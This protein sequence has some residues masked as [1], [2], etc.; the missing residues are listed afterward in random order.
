MIE[1]MGINGVP[2]DIFY[3]HPKKISTIRFQFAVDQGVLDEVCQRI[4]GS[5]PR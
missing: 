4:V 3:E 2:G 1:T 5:A